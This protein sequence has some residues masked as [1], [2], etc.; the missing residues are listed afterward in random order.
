MITRNIAS[1]L[2]AAFV[3]GTAVMGPVPIAQAA[4]CP[5]VEIVFARGTNEPPGIGGT[6]E[7]FVNDVRSKVGRKSVGVY[8][9]QYPASYDFPTAVD[10][11]NDAAAHIQATAANCP[12][13]KMVLG[14]FSQGAAV[15]GFVTS[16]A[17]PAGAT[18]YNGNGPMAPEVANHVAAVTL[19]GKPSAG[20][21]GLIGQPAVT[22]GPLYSGKTLDSCVPG[23]P[24]C[25]DGGDSAMHNQYVSDGL[26][27][28]AAAYAASRV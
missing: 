28:Q 23:D 16:N 2:G 12:K 14:G 6:G 18:D 17:V 22:I 24:V 5:D 20:V 11:I 3:V 9:V 8:G 13:T 26:V 10:G 7:A 15:I 4:S 25:S 1:M 27:D 19:F 21:M